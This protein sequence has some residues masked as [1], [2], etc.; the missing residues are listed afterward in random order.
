MSPSFINNTHFQL[1]H[2]LVRKMAFKFELEN[3]HINTHTSPRFFLWFSHIGSGK[4]SNNCYARAPKAREEKS[5]WSVH[6][7]WP[8]DAETGGRK[9]LKWVAGPYRNRWPDDPEMRTFLVTT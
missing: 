8:D 7:R 2:L 1:D 9:K 4:Q 6:H 3:L 5:I